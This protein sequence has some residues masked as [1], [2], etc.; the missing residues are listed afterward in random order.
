MLFIVSGIACAQQLDLSTL[1]KLSSKAS[2][3]STVTLD[4]AKLKLASQFL[5]SDNAQQDKA[6]GLISGLRGIFVRTF[7]FDKEG[8]YSSADLEPIRKQLTAPGWS[9]IINV[10]D[11]DETAEVWFFSKGD[12]LDGL[13]VIAGESKELAIVNIV[14]PID[15]NA[16][17][18]LGGSFGIPKIDSNVLGVDQ[19]ATTKPKPQPKPAAPKKDEDEE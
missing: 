10:K 11:R 5:S 16:L 18:K 13:A 1:E 12:V 6:K 14:G 17:S 2:E 15:I 7:E 3:S 4:S 8:A 19:K 9:N